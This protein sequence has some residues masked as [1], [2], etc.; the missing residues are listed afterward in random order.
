MGLQV[1]TGAAI[2]CSFGVTPSALAVLP[3]NRVMVGGV[4]AATIAD[5]M[6][7]VNIPPFGMCT[8]PANP[9]VAAATAAALGVLTPMPCV[10]VPAAWVPGSPTVMIGGTPALNDGSM[11]MCSYGGVITISFAGQAQTTVA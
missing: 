2:A 8:S 11:C 9:T 7:V 5:S 6:P 10:P 1:A 3:T 4:P